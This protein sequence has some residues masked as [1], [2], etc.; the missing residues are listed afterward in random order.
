MPTPQIQMIPSGYKSG[1]IYSVLPLDGLA[2]F[3][4]VRAS[5]KTRIN[6]SQEIELLAANVPSIDYTG[7]GCPSLLLEDLQTQLYGQNETMATQ[8]KTVTAVEHTVSFYGTGTIT[9]TGVYSGSLVGT[10]IKDRVQLTFTATAGA[11]VSTV[12]GSVNK[13]QLVTGNYVGSYIP[14]TTTGQI[15]RLAD[16]ASK[17]GLSSVINSE[18][19]VLYFNALALTNGG[20]SRR[21]SLSQGLGG[22]SNR[23]FFAYNPAE[24][25]FL[26]G[27]SRDG[28][29]LFQS[30]LTSFFNQTLNHKIAIKYSS[31]GLKVFVD[32]VEEFSNTINS[33]MIGLDTIDFNGINAF[34][35]YAEVKDLRVYSTL[36]DT[37]LTALTTL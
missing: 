11:L 16:E 7:G 27:V 20:D 10:G 35:F 1:K 15:T 14:N 5:V 19:G 29:N 2:D 24:N 33:T 4:F 13:S 25:R 30:Q 26:V 6:E 34:P 32:G 37:Q 8:T 17:T 28:V 31:T 22:S 3:D 21:I 23:L 9:F 36:T 12:S 18:E